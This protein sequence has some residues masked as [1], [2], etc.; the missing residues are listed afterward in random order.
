MSNWHFKDLE[1][2]LINNS[3]VILEEIYNTEH[4][5]IISSWKIQNLKSK[6]IRF[7]DFIGFDDLEKFPIE[8][9]YCC[10]LR[11][12]NIDLYFRKFRVKNIWHKELL[13]FIE[14]L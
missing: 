8:K 10:C 1:K 11:N 4:K 6:E 7:I 14:K 2:K 5:N 9:A 13:S 3:W 12:T